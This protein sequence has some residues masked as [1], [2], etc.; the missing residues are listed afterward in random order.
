MAGFLPGTVTQAG[1]SAIVHGHNQARP[2]QVLAEALGAASLLHPGPGTGLTLVLGSAGSATLMSSLEKLARTAR[3]G[4]TSSG[5]PPRSSGRDEIERAPLTR[6][7]SWPA[8][9][10]APPLGAP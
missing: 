9:R 1:Q 10:R 7:S 5:P 2:A 6:W 4:P 8:T 3:P